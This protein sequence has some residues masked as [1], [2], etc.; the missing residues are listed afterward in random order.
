MQ[1]CHLKKKKTGAAK[2]ECNEHDQKQN[3]YS[4]IQQLAYI[5]HYNH[6]LQRENVT[7]VVKCRNLKIRKS[8]RS[9]LSSCCLF[10][11]SVCE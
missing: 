7:Y 8:C 4:N 5:S 1:R 11:L 2:T 3:K 10:S 9:H 6:R